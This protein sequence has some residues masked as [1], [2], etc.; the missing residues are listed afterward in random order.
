MKKAQNEVWL[1]T[2]NAKSK[3]AC[4]NLLGRGSDNVL[5]QLVNGVFMAQLGDVVMQTLFTNLFDY[6]GEGAV[7][8]TN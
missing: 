8:E 5:G 3:Y 2:A 6:L 1:G 4:F 7:E